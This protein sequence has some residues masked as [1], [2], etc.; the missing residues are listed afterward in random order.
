VCLYVTIA[1]CV[2]DCALVVYSEMK[3]RVPT[4]THVIL[5]QVRSGVSAVTSL[6]DDVFV[7]HEYSQQI[8]VY[9]A[10][11][12]TLYS[13]ITIPGL[14]Y[15]A[16]GLAVCAVN[17]CIYASDLDN[18]S[19]HRVELSGSNAVKTWFVAR[20]PRGLS[21]NKAHNLVVTCYWAKKLQEYTTHGSLVREICLQAGVTDP[22]HAIQLSTGH[23][24][25]SQW[26]SPGV[27]SVVG[28]D[29]Q[30]IH[31][32]GPSETSDVGHM[33]CPSNLV[34]TK[35]DDIL[36]AD[37]DNHGILSII[38]STG[39]VQ[40][41]AL[42]VDGGIQVPGGLCLDESRGRLYVGEWGR[43]DRVLVFDGVKI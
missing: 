2:V 25:V 17:H 5:S 34:V 43:Q 27:V 29:G 13:L 35:N 28:V 8:E 39:C 40:E 15:C 18:N 37:T 3:S 7:V 32:Y 4:L 38:R 30:V 31:S 19:I 20:G 24:V 9:D 26:T 6:G 12:F 21:V 16:F 22:W 23:Y 36:V 41:L 10:E 42:S 14:G 1:V 33:K 11:T